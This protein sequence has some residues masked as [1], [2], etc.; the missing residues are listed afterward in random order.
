VQRRLGLGVAAYAMRLINDPRITMLLHHNITDAMW[1]ANDPS[2]RRGLTPRGMALAQLTRAVAD[3]KPTAHND[4]W[5]MQFGAH[6]Y[7]MSAGCGYSGAGPIR[8]DALIG[9]WFTHDHDSNG[10]HGAAGV[11]LNLGNRGVQLDLAGFYAT[12]ADVTITSASPD[13]ELDEVIQPA[14]TTTVHLD[15]THPRISLPA[16]GIARFVD[17]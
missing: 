8:Y 6:Q 17:H 16:P 1:P 13:D 14:T 15:A 2:G 12:G 3:A 7:Q 5:T 9:R 4:V 10:V 11:I